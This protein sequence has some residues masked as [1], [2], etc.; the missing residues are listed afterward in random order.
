MLKRV[1]VLDQSY[2]PISVVS[3][4]RAMK[5]LAKEKAEVVKTYER[6]IRSANSSWKVPAVVRFV[7]KF[8]RPRKMVKFSRKNIYARDRWYCQYCR[9]KFDPVDLTY[10]HVLPKS[11]GGKTDWQNI[12]TS[13]VECNLKKGSR[14]PQEAGM[15]LR[16][17]PVKPDWV[18]IFVVKLLRDGNIP[19]QWKEFCYGY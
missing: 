1:L 7:V 9:N 19:E 16:R 18:P 13:C 11:R 8:N 4:K 10:D 17:P 14:T 5:Y 15:P 3:F 12:V 2:M 6:K